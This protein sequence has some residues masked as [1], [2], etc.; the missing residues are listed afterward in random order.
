M[1]LGFSIR[2]FVIFLIPMLINIV[3]FLLPPVNER[4]QG[5][6]GVSGNQILTMIEQGSRIAYATAICL[7]VSKKKIDV[8]SPFLYIA[9]L[10]LILYYIVWIRYFIGGR[11]IKLL[12]S[13]FLF[14]PMPLAIFPVI[15][16]LFAAL[17]LHNYYAFG[18][19]ILFGI[20]HNII[21]YQTLYYK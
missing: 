2:G 10:F 20:A 1:K 8:K 15:Y 9:I 5:G 12:G 6:A 17:W 18:F 4:K 16:F 3:Y 13:S 19:M 7:L 14:I 11:N 21:S